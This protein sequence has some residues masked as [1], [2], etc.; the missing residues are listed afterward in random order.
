MQVSEKAVCCQCLP[1]AELCVLA[2]MTVILLM[3]QYSSLHSSQ[4][5]CPSPSFHSLGFFQPSAA[6]RG[7]HSSK[8]AAMSPGLGSSWTTGSSGGQGSWSSPS[9]TRA[10][11]QHY[12]SHHHQQHPHHHPP[13]THT[14][15]TYCTAHTAVSNAF[16]L[17]VV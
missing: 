5:F 1:A 4:S 12:I 13:S 10:S 8:T 11:L 6:V 16:S 14:S 7:Y 17:F 2:V 15:Y 3:Y 9:F